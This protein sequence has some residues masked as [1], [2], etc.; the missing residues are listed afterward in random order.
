MTGKANKPE[1][2]SPEKK[3]N[4]DYDSK[5][6]D[7][8]NRFASTD[9]RIDDLKWSLTGWMTFFGIIFGVSALIFNNNFNA[10]KEGL[11]QLSKEMRDELNGKSYNASLEFQSFNKHKL[12]GQEVTGRIEEASPGKYL[13]EFSIILK[14][15]GESSTGPITIKVY[16]DSSLQLYDISTDEEKYAYEA[17]HH[18]NLHPDRLPALASFEANLYMGVRKK[19]TKGKYQVLVKGYCDNSKAITKDEF[20]LI[21][22]N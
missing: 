1:S 20:N 3:E 6:N 5:F 13:L 22:N 2:S 17:F 14:N 12:S 7:I 9:K 8:N 16:T 11:R 21:I 10:E 18:D 15:T 4:T 19:P